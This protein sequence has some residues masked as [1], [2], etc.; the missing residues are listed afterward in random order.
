VVSLGHQNGH[1]ILPHKIH[2][3]LNLLNRCLNLLHF[4]YYYI[5]ICI[6]MDITAADTVITA[7]SCIL[8]NNLA[9]TAQWLLVRIVQVHPGSDRLTRVITLKTA[10]SIF[11]RP[12]H[13]RY[14]RYDKEGWLSASWPWRRDRNACG[15]QGQITQVET[16]NSES[17]LQLL[18]SQRVA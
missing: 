6:Q 15:Y 11:K 5:I 14:D 9:L 18:F 7:E 8:K 16:S 12:G 17:L 3:V 10:R 2:T 13:R 4:I 1:R